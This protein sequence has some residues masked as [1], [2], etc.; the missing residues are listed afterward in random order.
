MAS[1]IVFPPPVWSNQN[2]VLYH[3]TLAAYAQG[4]R[5]KVQVAFGKPNK[6]FGPGFYLTTRLHQA[7]D[8]A[9]RKAAEK[10]ADTAAPAV[11]QITVSREALAGLQT[12]A[13]VQGDF[14]AEDY[15]RFVH[16]CRDGAV[17]HGRPFPQ[18]YYDVVYGPVS[19]F[20]NQRTIYANFDR[21]SF[22]TPATEEVLNL[23]SRVKQQS[24]DRIILWL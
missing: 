17:D 22:H 9:D 20:Q 18:I 10:P 14:D 4:I 11:V 7:R 23:S 6:D 15:W 1:P 8:W 24:I 3:G 12:L 5:T 2:I 21:V 13:F 19:K 16:Y